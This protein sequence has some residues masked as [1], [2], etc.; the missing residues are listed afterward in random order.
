M[1]AKA[2]LQSNVSILGYVT[3][4]KTSDGENSAEHNWAGMHEPVV[5]EASTCLCQDC[6]QESNCESTPSLHARTFMQLLHDVKA[7]LRRA[8]ACT[9]VSAGVWHSTCTLVRDRPRHPTQFLIQIE[10][11]ADSSQCKQDFQRMSRL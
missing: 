10:A 9:A 5:E 11:R 4:R 1:S 2:P 6:L 7:A 3:H 8:T